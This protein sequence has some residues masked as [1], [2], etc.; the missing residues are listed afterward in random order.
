MVVVPI[1]TMRNSTFFAIISKTT[2]SC[3]IPGITI[4]W[5]LETFPNFPILP[6][7][8]WICLELCFARLQYENGWK[9]LKNSENTQYFF[10]NKMY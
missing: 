8:I 1:D 2:N 10:K 5:F 9:M 6:K 3:H 7:K 4:F